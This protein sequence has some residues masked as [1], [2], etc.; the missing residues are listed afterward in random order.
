MVSGLFGCVQGCSGLF[1]IL[2]VVHG[3]G[4]LGLGGSWF[5]FVRSVFLKV[6]QRFGMCLGINGCS[7]LPIPSKHS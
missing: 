1:W 3:L 4:F 2:G 5:S 7:C 6:D